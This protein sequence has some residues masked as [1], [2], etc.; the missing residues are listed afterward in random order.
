MKGTIV[1][2]KLKGGRISW[3]YIFDVSRDQNGRRRQVMRK[4]FPTKRE[5]ED[6]LRTAIGDHEKGRGIKKDPQMFETFFKTWLEQHGAAHWGKMTA[7]QNNKRAAYAIRKFGDIPVQKLTSMRLEQ[8]FGALLANGGVET[9]KYPKGRPLSPKTVC[10]IAALVA[11]ALDKAVKW[12][13]IERN[14]MDDVERPTAHRKEAHFPE[15]DEYEKY[16]N[17][18]QGTRYYALNVFAAAAG[19]R[20]VN[21]W[22]CGGP[23]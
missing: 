15:P 19:C 12:K 16:L 13:L 10:E 1:K 4:G 6:A 21:C 23:I 5:A 9:T 3:G 18:V 14:P 7:E 8:D 20:R 17:R 22:P 11:Q 2:K